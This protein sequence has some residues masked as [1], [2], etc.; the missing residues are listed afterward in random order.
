MSENNQQLEFELRQHAYDFLAVN[1]VSEYGNQIGEW[2]KYINRVVDA[3]KEAVRNHQ[4]TLNKMAAEERAKAEASAMFAMLAL[5]LVTGPLLSWIS[6]AIQYKLVPKLTSVTKPRFVT[7]GLE[8]T[9]YSNGKWISSPP[10]PIGVFTEE[11]HNKVTAKIFGDL[12]EDA[13]AKIGG[14]VMSLFSSSEK[15]QIPK[16]QNGNSYQQITLLANQTNNA[17]QFIN[18]LKT[19]LENALI[20]EKEKTINAII[21]LATAIKRNLN[22]GKLVLEKMYRV[23]PE[24][25]KLSGNQL[26]WAAYKYIEDL[27]D[28]DREKWAEDWFYYGNNPPNTST[29]EMSRTIER[30]IWGLWILD[31]EFKLYIKIPG[32]R[33]SSDEDLDRMQNLIPMPP[34][35]PAA[36]GRDKLPFGE[37]LLRRLADLNIVPPRT[38]L[39]ITQNPSMKAPVSGI[40]RNV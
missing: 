2:Q 28:E 8:Q 11:T 19:T 38:Y 37:T 24:T 10:L 29:F 26:K 23:K 21:G 27:V 34:P 13:A 20:D 17:D 7:R 22:F 9:V 39:Q 3:E 36:K 1:T 15:Q 12:G 32:P 33:H 35:V 25:K 6:G 18:S 16:R 5:S 30:E 31:Q 40:V 14:G 4:D